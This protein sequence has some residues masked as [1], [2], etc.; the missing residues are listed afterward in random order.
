LPNPPTV[1]C[2]TAPQVALD[3]GLTAVWV[4]AT[5]LVDFADTGTNIARVGGSAI[6]IGVQHGW[7]RWYEVFGVCRHCHRS[8]VFVLSQRNY[9]DKN[10]LN[11]HSPLE[12]DG[13]LNPHF[14]I[15]SFIS[16]KDMVAVTA[17][18]HVP[19]PVKTAFHEGAVSVA[20]RNWNAAGVMFRL[21]IDL[22]TRPMLPADETQ[23]LN[24]RIRR[25]LGLRLPWLFDRGFLPEGLRE[26]STCVRED[27]NDGAHAG[28]LTK[29]DA[30]DLQDFTVALLERIFT[31]PE[32]LRLAKERRDKRRQPGEE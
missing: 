11:E 4:A 16:H 9:Q 2:S 18:D 32:Q 1:S 29:E 25:D 7:Q 5:V 30:E 3:F 15:D 22:T 8:T 13:A 27:G 23:A 31:E 10:F 12:L 28:T 26:L 24:K 20:V 21:A 14:N 19:E 6:P 17:P